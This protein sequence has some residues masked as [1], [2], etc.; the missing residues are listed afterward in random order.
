MKIMVSHLSVRSKGLVLVMTDDEDDG[1]GDGEDDGDY[2]EEEVDLRHLSVKPKGLV[3]SLEETM[4]NAE[5]A[6]RPSLATLIK[7]LI[8]FIF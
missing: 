3:K 8:N 2:D 5:A 4:A 1:D 7:I 6:V